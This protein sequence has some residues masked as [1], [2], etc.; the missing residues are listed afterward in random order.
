[1]T[2]SNLWLFLLFFL[3]ANVSAQVSD[4]IYEMAGTCRYHGQ[5]LLGLEQLG[6]V[7]SKYSPSRDSFLKA[8]KLHNLTRPFLLVG[9]SSTALFVAYGLLSKDFISSGMGILLGL[10]VT[11]TITGFGLSIATSRMVSH[12]VD[13][14]NSSLQKQ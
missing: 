6:P 8:T 13:L 11:C 5:E 9:L 14:Y 4:S 1:M 10:S 7:L 2:K 3:T 12:S